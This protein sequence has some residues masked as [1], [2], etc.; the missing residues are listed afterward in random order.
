MHYSIDFYVAARLALSAPR[1]KRSSFCSAVSAERR[2]LSY[3]LPCLN[4]SSLSIILQFPVE[5]AP[6]K[7]VVQYWGLFP[8]VGMR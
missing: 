8:P 2:A 1:D 5:K 4:V 6:D 3:S 7:A